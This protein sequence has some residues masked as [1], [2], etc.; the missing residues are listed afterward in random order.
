MCVCSWWRDICWVVHL[1]ENETGHG[2]HRLIHTH[3]HLLPNVHRLFSLYCIGE[4]EME[5]KDAFLFI[6]NHSIVLDLDLTEMLNVVWVWSM[7]Y[8]MLMLLVKFLE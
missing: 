2:T 4:G 3:R 7:E 8:G 6:P 5:M 1:R